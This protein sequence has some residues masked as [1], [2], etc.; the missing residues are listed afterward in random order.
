MYLSHIFT[1]CVFGDFRVDCLG[2]FALGVFGLSLFLD[3]RVTLSLNLSVNCFY[4]SAFA[5]S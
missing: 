2:T 3:F 4:F 1:H 5:V